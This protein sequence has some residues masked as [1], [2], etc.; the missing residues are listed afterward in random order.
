MATSTDPENDTLTY[1]WNFGDG[2]ALGTGATPSHAYASAAGAPYTVTLTVNDGHG[3][4]RHR[5]GNGQ[6]AGRTRPGNVAFVGSARD[7]GNRS[8]HA[9]TLPTNVQVGDTMVLFFGAASIAPTYTGPNGW[10][11]LETQN[12]T[13]AM[14]RPGL[15]QEAT[16]AADEVDGLK[17]TVTS[18]AAAKSDL[19]R[20]RLPR[21]RRHHADRR[22]GVEDR[23]RRGCRAHQ[24]DRH[25][26]GRAPTGW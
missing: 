14:T 4:H 15:D 24:P 7:G 10:T 17:V 8:T 13:T 20:G 12:G 6:P 2:T 23:Q 5:H 3:A 16:V 25:L 18:S 1:S 22:L 19:S 21:H 9:V 26:D 11:L